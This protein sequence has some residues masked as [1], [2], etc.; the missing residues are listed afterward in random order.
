M[1]KFLPLC[2]GLFSLAAFQT[3]A[4]QATPLPVGVYTLSASTPTSGIHSGSDVGT[5]SGTLIFDAGSNLTF[6]NLAFDDM[7][8]SRIFTFTVS[9]PTTVYIPPGLL[10][11][12]VYNAV[13]PSQY[14]AFSIRVPSTPSGAFT[15]TCGTDCDNWMLVDDGLPNLV[16]V[17]V[18]GSIT[19]AAVPEP[20]TI[21]LLGSG[22]LAIL[23]T[24]RRL[25]SMSRW[26]RAKGGVTPGLRQ[27]VAYHP[28]SASPPAPPESSLAAA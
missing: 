28:E 21:A 27:T 3:P 12:T 4:V 20:A 18:A 16:Y 23:G 6:A 9:G 2:L 11:A 14:Y 10:G 22:V 5:L 1:R 8:S 26:F 13:D 24:R 15:L 25:S 17:E 19:P 7:T